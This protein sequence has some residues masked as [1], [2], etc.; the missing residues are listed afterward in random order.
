MNCRERNMWRAEVAARDELIEYERRRADIAQRR[1]MKDR[2][3]RSDKLKE[4]YA[5]A[6][7]IVVLC[8][9]LTYI[10][11]GLME[12]MAWATGN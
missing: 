7:L 4:I 10:C 12:F 1:M 8:F 9:G 5:Y 11:W 3:Q 2:K 6:V